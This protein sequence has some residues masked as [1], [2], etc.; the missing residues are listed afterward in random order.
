MFSLVVMVLAASPDAGVL[1]ARP[2][3]I[4]A[5]HLDVDTKAMT[6]VYSGQVRALR[7]STTLTCDRLDVSFGEGEQ[8]KA[9]HGRGHVWA[10]DGD[11]QATGDEAHY[12][13]LTGILTLWGKPS[14]RSGTK[15]VT[16]E[17]VTFTTGTEKTQVRKPRTKVK[18]LPDGGAGGDKVIIIDADALVLESQKSTATWTGHVKAVRE[19][20]VLTAPLLVATYDAQGSITHLAASGTVEVTEGDRWATGKNADYDVTKGILVVTGQPR[21]RQGNNRMKGTKVI[22]FPGTDFIEVE[23]AVTNIEVDK[24]KIDR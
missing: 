13:N 4:K 2:V 20:T 14:A 10:T 16:G 11:R 18:G 23:N 9:I 24:N 6:G 12:D 22:F 17:F 7:D 15:E 21:A 3:E 19:A 5:Q 1:L 8:V